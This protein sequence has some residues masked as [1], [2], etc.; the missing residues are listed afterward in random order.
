[1]SALK[2]PSPILSISSTELFDLIRVHCGQEVLDIVLAQKISNIQS[3]LRVHDLFALVHLQ[4]DQFADLRNKVAVQL[5]D[6]TWSVLLGFQVRVDEFMHALRNQTLIDDIEHGQGLDHLPSSDQY[7]L[8]PQLTSQFPFLTTL[9]EHCSMIST[10]SNAENLHSIVPVLS[11]I[12]SNLARSR[13]NLR[14]S[15]YIMQ[16]ACSLFVYGGEN[17]YQFVSINMPG[18]LPSVTKIRSMLGSRS[19]RLWEAEFRFDG[20]RDHF[21]TNNSYLAFAAED[22][23]GIIAKVTYDSD[24]DCFVG[25][26]TPLEEGRPLSRHY[27]TDSYAELQAWFEEKSK[28]TYVNV[29]VLQPLR[30][31][32]TDRILSPFVLAAYGVD[33]KFTAEDVRNRWLWMYEQA[34]ERGIRILG[35][36]TDADARYLR[37]MRLASGFFAWEPDARFVHHPDAFKINVPSNWDWFFIGQSQLCLFFQVSTSFIEQEHAVNGD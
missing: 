27:R 7:V 11:G 13:N 9:V 24:S 14:Y 37:S 6:G 35:F 16:F 21:A 28:S 15:T 18:F 33:G 20:M 30:N 4:T 22:L 29:H 17:A 1:M 25:F 5:Y 10:A 3:L 19:F 36:A 32:L 34:K 2:L 8:S 31:S 23:T 26:N 12:C